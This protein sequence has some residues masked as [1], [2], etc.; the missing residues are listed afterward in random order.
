MLRLILFSTINNIL[1]S[2]KRS[3][4][5]FVFFKAAYHANPEAERSFA[6]S[7]SYIFKTHISNVLKYSS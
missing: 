3:N 7:S 5:T 1:V 6:G 2:I 4:S